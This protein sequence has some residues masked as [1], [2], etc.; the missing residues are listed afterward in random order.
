MLAFIKLLAIISLFIWDVTPCGSNYYDTPDVKTRTKRDYGDTKGGKSTRSYLPGVLNCPTFGTLCADVKD[1]PLDDVYKVVESVKATGFD[2]Y[3]EFIDES[4]NDVKPFQTWEEQQQQKEEAD[5]G[6]E[7]Q[8]NY[9]PNSTPKPNY[10]LGTNTPQES[11]PNYSYESQYD[12]PN[13]NRHKRETEEVLEPACAVRYAQ[14]DPRAGLTDKR[15]WK[16]VANA[17]DKDDRLKQTLKVELCANPGGTCVGEGI[18]GYGLSSRCTQKYL[19][20]KL[21]SFDS[22]GKSVST[23]HF[24]VPSCCACEIVRLN[25]KA[26]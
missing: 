25:R 21:L 11:T 2:I 8:Y 7:V 9:K 1:Y 16:Y 22:T 20:K 26:K 3:T 17:V 13:T 23:E 5:E 15:Y 24:F 19:K 18:L 12:N 10:E 6:W 14:I 4:K